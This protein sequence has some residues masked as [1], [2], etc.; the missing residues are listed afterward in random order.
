MSSFQV[1]PAVASDLTAIK[2]IADANKTAL[3]FLPRPKIS[4]AIQ[5]ERVLVLQT[6]SEL[7]GFV[8]YRHRK[9]DSQT[10]LSDICV[11]KKWRGNQGGKCLV[12]TLVNDCVKHRREFILL[13]CPVDLLANNFYK[14]MGFT[15]V[16]VDKGKRRPLNIWRF[17]I[18]NNGAG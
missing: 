7:V 18:D 8:I 16:S 2:K 1:R 17:D 4:D 3:G 14:Q 5:Q 15:K 13:K 9:K 11:M 10:T 6:D 12:Q